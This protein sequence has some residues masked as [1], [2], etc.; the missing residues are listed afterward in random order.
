MTLIEEQI[1]IQGDP[2]NHQDHVNLLRKGIPNPGGTWADLGSGRGAFTLALA[3]LI[4]PTDHIYSID[5]DPSALRDQE[6][7]IRTQ[8]PSP[9]V[10]YLTADF[11]QRLALPPVHAIE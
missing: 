6:N 3:D 5:R 2:M 8:F 10:H 7:A 1:D 9:T 11:T 4:V